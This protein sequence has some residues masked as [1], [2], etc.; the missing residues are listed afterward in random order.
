MNAL[1]RPSAIRAKGPGFRDFQSLSEETPALETGRLALG[2][3]C[4][5]AYPTRVLSQRSAD[6]RKVRPICQSESAELY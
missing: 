4:P 5:T 3:V 2:P 6:Y 1:P